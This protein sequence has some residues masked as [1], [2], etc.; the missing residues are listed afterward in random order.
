MKIF[1]KVILILIFFS[2]IYFLLDKFLNSP[3]LFVNFTTD[4]FSKKEDI[5]KDKNKNEE[6]ILNLLFVGDIMT[7]R[8]IRKQ[9]EKSNSIDEFINSFLASLQKE[10]KNYDFVVANLEGPITENPTKSILA[11]GSYSKDLL[12]TFPSSTVQILKDLNIKA[13]SLAN[14]HT[15]NFYYKGFLET[16]T[17]LDNGNIK[18]F[19]N[20]YNSEKDNISNIICEKEIC[21]ALIGYNQFTKENSKDIFIKEIEKL[22]S[23]TKVD[24]IIVMPHWGEEYKLL[25]NDFQKSLAKSFID[26]GADMVI[27]SHPHVAQEKEIYKDKYIYYSLGNYIFDQWFNEDVKK[28]LAVNVIFKKSISKGN[29]EKSIEIKKEIKVLNAKDGVRYE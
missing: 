20:A 21:I 13:V 28:G 27:G 14:N 10:N 7:D 23:D 19:G 22:K 11:D 2:A 29:I 17:F 16:K 3:A 8:Y 12:F 5:E 4:E 6:N 1:I 25:S 24:F 18:Y 15:D 9:I 26:A